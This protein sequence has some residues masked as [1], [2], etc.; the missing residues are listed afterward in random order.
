[1]RKRLLIAT[2][3]IVALLVPAV[4]LGATTVKFTGTF[5]DD[6]NATIGFNVKRVNG[7]NKQVLDM[8]LRR[9]NVNCTKSGKTEIRTNN[10]ITINAGVQQ[11]KWHYDDGTANFQGTFRKGNKNKADGTLELTLSGID[12]GN[13]NG[14]ENCHGGPRTFHAHT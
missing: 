13:G 2:G 12:F 1:M 11:R 5:P 4:A 7:Q 9:F 10:P 3:I 14:P 6:A 8:S